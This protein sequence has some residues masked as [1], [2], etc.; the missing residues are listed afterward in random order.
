MPDLLNLVIT[1]EKRKNLL[2]LLKSRPH[3][4]DE[5]KSLLNVTA[6]GMLPQIRILEDRG[7]I[8]KEGK[9]YELT[10]IG[11]LIV[12][13]LRPL[14]ETT[15]VIEQQKAYWQDHDIE[16]LPQELLVRLGEIKNP[17]IIETSVEES[18][19][20]HNQ[21]LD[22]ILSSKRVAGISPIVHPVYPKFFLG[23]A[24]TGREVR[25]ILTRSAYAK[26]KKEYFAM[27][28]EGLR[29]PNAELW[30]CDEDLRFAFIVTDRYFSM[31]LF[32]KS[33]IFDSKR[34]VVSGE[35]QALRWGEDLFSYYR[36]RSH[37]VTLEEIRSA[38]QA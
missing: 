25:L 33:G 23:F 4:W 20:P 10:D 22:M 11:R 8:R 16:A 31:G 19:E 14:E 36:D 1:S 17:R 30:I 32:M 2:L 18:F 37:R 38:Q 9:S 24:S 29:Y 28:A 12:H 27:L 13:Y 15:T 6:T 3:S 7:L 26:I 21:F 5:I 35:P 34:D